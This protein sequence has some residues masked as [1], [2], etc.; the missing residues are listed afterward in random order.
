MHSVCI[1][2]VQTFEKAV[3]I[4]SNRSA[5]NAKWNIGVNRTLR[6]CEM[7]GANITRCAT[8]VDVVLDPVDGIII[9]IHRSQDSRD[10]SRR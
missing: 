8:K 3:E 9:G 1:P 4:I 10:H 5:L 7:S 2:V 6:S